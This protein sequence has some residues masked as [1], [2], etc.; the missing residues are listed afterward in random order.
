MQDARHSRRIVR[1]PRGILPLV[2]SGKAMMRRVDDFRLRFGKQELVPI[3]IGGMGVDI[4]TADL[5]L[6]AA[7]LGGIGHI[8]DA[9]I[10][11]VSDR[12]YNTKFVKEKLALYKLS[13][14]SEDKS[15]VKFDL[16]HLVEATRADLVAGYVGQSA[17]KTRE[18]VNSALDGVLFI[19]EA[20]SLSRGSENDFGKEAVDFIAQAGASGYI[21][22]GSDFEEI[23]AAIRNAAGT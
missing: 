3:M 17:L 21:L 4:S 19:D 8:S 20:Y 2:Y 9:M 10:K 11:T 15:L 18:V 14:K 22:K 5:A 1:W 7:R 23:S 13:V 6:E 16:G 12:R